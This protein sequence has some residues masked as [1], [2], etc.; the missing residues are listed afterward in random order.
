MI[1]SHS[2]L[3]KMRNTSQEICREIKTHFVSNIFLAENLACYK[4]MCK[5]M[6]E[7]DSTQTTIR[8]M[9]FASRIIKA[10]DTRICN[11]NCFSRARMVS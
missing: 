6:I 3:L 2:F 11:T 1:I 5:I 7:R 4:V 10:T 8:S 9:R